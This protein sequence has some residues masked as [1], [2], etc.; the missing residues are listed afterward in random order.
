MLYHIFN[1]NNNNI[2]D[3]LFRNCDIKCS[4]YYCID[5]LDVLGLTQLPA[6]LP[7]VHNDAGILCSAEQGYRRI[8]VFAEIVNNCFD[9]RNI[10]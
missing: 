9:L 1:L 4:R 8:S 2:F 5:F 6:V 7:P 3:I 10:S